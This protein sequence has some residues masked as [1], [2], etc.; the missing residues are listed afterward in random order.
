MATV[1]Q[2][3]EHLVNLTVK[4]VNKLA[5]VLKEKHGIEPAAAAVAAPIIGGTAEQVEEKSAFDIVLK[6][7]G[8]T[9]LKVIKAVKEL[10]GKTLTEA[11]ELVDAAPK[12]VLK[13]G[14]NKEEAEGLKK[15]LEETGAEIELT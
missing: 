3:A 6:S 15:Q 13:Q 8:A 11:K 2:L 5:N 7:A 1:E 10:M 14:A 12:A 4:D 9:K